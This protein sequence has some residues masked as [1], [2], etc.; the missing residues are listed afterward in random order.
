MGVVFNVMGIDSGF[1][2]LVGGWTGLLVF[3]AH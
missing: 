2:Q 1:T 3:L